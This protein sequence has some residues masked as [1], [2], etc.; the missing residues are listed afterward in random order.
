[1]EYDHHA[2]QRSTEYCQQALNLMALH[3]IT[4]NPTNF[5]IWYCHVSGEWPSLSKTLEVLIA[6][7]EEFTAPRS[8]KLY[9]SLFSPP[10]EALP[11]HSMVERLESELANVLDS[12]KQA[13]R[14]ASDYGKFL[15]TATGEVAAS[16]S[17]D[18]VRQIVGRLLSQTRAMALQS[19]ELE[20][21]LQASSSEVAK[22]KS[23]LDGARR[24]ALVDALTGLGNRKMFDCVLRKATI[25]ATESGEP[26][27]LLLLDVDHFKKFN[28]E[29]GHCI[30]DQ[31]LRVV[32]VM[33]GENIKGQDTAARYGGE[34]FAIVLPR[35][36]SRD[37]RKLAE[38]IRARSCE[39]RLV[40]RKTGK[41][42]GQVSVSIGVAEFASP[43]PLSRF[44]E[45]ADRALYSA[46]Q[47]GR[48]R[49]VV[50]EDWSKRAI[51]RI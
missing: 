24:E 9:A 27:C 48:N 16:Q 21:Q 25:A 19:L 10:N 7:G 17:E 35:T 49:V 41:D 23:E 39:K 15:E 14:D 51:V 20:K 44:I 5:T 1:M 43:E 50:A 22:L 38:N 37:A 34:E 45:R 36:T 31:V 18:V 12:L 33:L 3:Q 6:D 26:L 13:G 11:L 29:F 40:I 30:G 46:K 2:L 47:T 28:D 32:A 4:P 42:L 8:A